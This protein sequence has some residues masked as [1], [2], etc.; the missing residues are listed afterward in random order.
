MTNETSDSNNT[1]TAN[2]AQPV[3]KCDGVYK[4][5]GDNTADH[6]GEIEW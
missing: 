6:D 4:I 5:F 2:D 3:I 1:S